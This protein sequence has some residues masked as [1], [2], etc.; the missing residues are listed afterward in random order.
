MFQ[1]ENRLVSTTCFTAS[2]CPCEFGSPPLHGLRSGF[3][4]LGAMSWRSV[5]VPPLT[6]LSQHCFSLHKRSISSIR[7]R[8]GAGTYNAVK[9]PSLSL[10]D[11][12]WQKT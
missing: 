2:T 4:Q 3:V 8:A 6:S 10:A 9:V 5:V 12:I 11:G 1:D 7:G